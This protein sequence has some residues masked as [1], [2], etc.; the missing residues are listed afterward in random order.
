MLNDE[1]A[2]T[3]S[4]NSGMLSREIVETADQCDYAVIWLHGLGADGHDFVPI[5]PQMKLGSG[6]GFRFI[7]P[8]APVIP[9]T[10][11]GNMEMRA[12]YD[13]RGM[14]MNRDQDMDGILATAARIQALIDS[15]YQ[16]GID[17]HNIFLAGFSQGGAMAMYVGLRYPQRLAGIIA[18]SSYQ[19]LSDQLEAERSDANRQTPVFIAHGV[20]DP[21]VPFIAGESSA[22]QLSGMNYPVS[23][24]SYNMQHNVCMEEIQDV[25]AWIA[26]ISDDV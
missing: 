7:F 22:K 1:S 26:E 11:N 8:H 17:H 19:L 14:S 23:W 3:L 9:V 6:H 13:I 15:E 5:V 21:V 10:I 25:S 16:K 18:L 2:N 12:W 24:Q 4:G 20:Q